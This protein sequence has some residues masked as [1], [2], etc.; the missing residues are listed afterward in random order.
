[1][2]LLGDTWRFAIQGLKAPRSTP[3]RSLRCVWLLSSVLPHSFPSRAAWEKAS[4]S[5]RRLW[6]I[7]GNE[8]IRYV[9]TE[10]Q[11]DGPDLGRHAR[12]AKGVQDAEW[13][14]LDKTSLTRKV[15]VAFQVAQT[16]SLEL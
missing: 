7:I 9:V 4:V 15:E 16:S 3:A 2:S 14:D 11:N 5:T 1:M 10:K 13:T 12:E 8:L 6:V